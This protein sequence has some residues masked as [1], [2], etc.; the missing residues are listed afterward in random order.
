M[1][2]KLLAVLTPPSIYHSFFIQ[3]TFWEEIFAP[4]NMKDCGCRNIRKH[5][6]IKYGEKYITLEISLDFGSLDKMKIP[7][8][9]PKQYLGRSGKGLITSLGLNTIRR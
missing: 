1:N 8:S 3:K 6:E 5:R 9:E 4:V 7:S 2:M